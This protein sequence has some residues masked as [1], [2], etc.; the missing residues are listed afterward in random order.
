[1]GAGLERLDHPRALAAWLAA[2][3][4]D[5]GLA[6]EPTGAGLAAARRLRG[7]IRR[8]ALHAMRAPPLPA[9]DAAL[10]NAA[11]AHAPPR[12]RAAAGLD[13]GLAAEP[14]DAGLEAAR[15]LREAIHRCALHA[16]R[17]QP[18]PAGDVA[19]RTAAAAHPPLRPRLEG[20]TVRWHAGRPFEAALSTLAADAIALF[21]SQR[22]ARIRRCPGCAM[23]FEDTSRPGK[24]RWCSSARGCGNREKTRNLRGRKRRAQR[25]ATPHGDDDAH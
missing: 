16:M 23:L 24:R 2:A 4:L 21:G 11:A 13:G 6:A 14:T 15:R 19:L 1:G 8:C 3:G 22:R 5:G 7:A 18:L 17:A 20:E 25:S 10:L 9:G 12:P